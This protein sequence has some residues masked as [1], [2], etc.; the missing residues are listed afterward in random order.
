MARDQ[1]LILAN[2][3][4]PLI[5]DKLIGELTVLSAVGPVPLFGYLCA[6]TQDSC[7]GVVTVRSTDSEAELQPRLY[8]PEGEILHIWRLGTTNKVRLTF[9]VTIKPRY[10][11]YDALLI[12]VQPY[13]KTIPACSQC[14]S[15][16]PPRRL[17]WP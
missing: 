3:A 15:V 17:P 6:D 4:N 9:S 2:T 8:W 7:Y 14:G 10:V 16:A 12:L 13:K 11:T 1:A 5:A